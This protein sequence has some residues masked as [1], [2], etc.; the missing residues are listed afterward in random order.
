MSAHPSVDAAVEVPARRGASWQRAVS[1]VLLVVTAVVA[2]ALAVAL[3]SNVRTCSVLMMIRL[4]P[5]CPDALRDSN[6]D[7]VI[8][9]RYGLLQQP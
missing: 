8:S 1:S 3:Y 4:F 7:P 9:G 2:T 6:A 5:L